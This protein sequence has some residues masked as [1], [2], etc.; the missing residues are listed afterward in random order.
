MDRRPLVALAARRSSLVSRLYFA[1]KAPRA[2]EVKT[3]LGATIGMRDAAMLYEAFIRDLNARF[4]GA[5]HEVAW[6]VAPGSWSHIKRLVT[7][8]DAIRVQRG[9]D[10]ATRQAN[11]FSDCQVA[12]EAPVVLAASDS[13]QLGRARV[14]EAFAALTTNDVVLGPTLDGGYYLVGMR[15]GEDIFTGIEMSTSSAFEG[16]LTKARD[17]GLSVLALAPEFDVDVESDLDRLAAEVE[18]RNDLRST[19]ATLA[20]IREA[21]VRVA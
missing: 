21:Q 3:R 12:G 1:A 6:H 19:A 4:A 11:L 10:W 8:A 15:R 17:K 18:L 2:G 14:A 9:L 20:L 13:P 5:Q 7:R 16:V